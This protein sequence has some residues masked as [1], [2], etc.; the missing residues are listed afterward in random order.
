MERNINIDIIT[1]VRIEVNNLMKR[2]KQQ[3]NN[4]KTLDKIFALV[5]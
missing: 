5:H 3:Q 1:H 4:C 2:D